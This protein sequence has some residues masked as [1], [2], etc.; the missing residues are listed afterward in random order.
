MVLVGLNYISFD[1]RPNRRRFGHEFVTLFCR[2]DNVF[3]T[4]SANEGA[5]HS[6]GDGAA[7]ASGPPGIDFAIWPPLI[8]LTKIYVF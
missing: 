4:F 6:L 5:A 8:G 1:V 2:F 3:V 7:L